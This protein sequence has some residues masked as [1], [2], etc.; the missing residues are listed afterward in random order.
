M[1]NEE[2]RRTL[3]EIVALFNQFECD[4]GDC[5]TDLDKM[6]EILISARLLRNSMMDEFNYRY[7][8][9]ENP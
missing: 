6:P 4:G 3:M 1:E 5:Y 7:R 9:K 8:R 2:F